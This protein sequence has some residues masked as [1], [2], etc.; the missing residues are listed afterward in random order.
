[1]STPKEQEA[2][3]SNELLDLGNDIYAEVSVYNGK[4][5][6]S[7]RRWFQADDGKWYRTKNGLH[8]RL[9]AMIEVFAHM[10]ELVKF[11]QARGARLE[12]ETRG[13]ATS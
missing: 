10:E 3:V 9:D 7:I 11:V 6:A 12:G 5:F 4:T 13:G 8:V 1:M 2:R